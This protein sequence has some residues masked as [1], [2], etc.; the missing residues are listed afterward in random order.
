MEEKFVY[1]NPNGVV[2]EY[3][4]KDGKFLGL[5]NDGVKKDEDPLPIGTPLDKGLQDNLGVA[6]FKK[7]Q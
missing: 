2:T 4:F 6:G 7:Y 5:F 3:R 1:K